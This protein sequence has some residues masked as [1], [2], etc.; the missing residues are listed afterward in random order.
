MPLAADQGHALAQYAVGWL[1][2]RGRGV[3]EDDAEAVRWYRLAADQPRFWN[4]GTAK[5]CTI[6]VPVEP[7]SLGFLLSN[8][9]W[10]IE[11]H[12]Y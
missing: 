5:D 9:I 11:I 1:Y 7:F 4:M 6:P 8:E 12:L 3:P 2:E 10:S